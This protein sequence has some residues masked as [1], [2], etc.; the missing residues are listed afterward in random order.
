MAGSV[1]ASRDLTHGSFTDIIITY[2]SAVP[3]KMISPQELEL[4]QA[5]LPIDYIAEDLY[6]AA[7]WLLK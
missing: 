5:G 3:L 6:D 4:A 7:Q 2:Q 1:D